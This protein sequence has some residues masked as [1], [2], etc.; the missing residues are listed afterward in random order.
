MPHATGHFWLRVF[1][2]ILNLK[3]IRQFTIFSSCLNIIKLLTLA[4]WFP[5]LRCCNEC[6]FAGVWRSGGRKSLKVPTHSARNS[7]KVWI[8]NRG[9]K[10]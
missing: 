6:R 3:K 5:I 4:D 9:L 2:V 7:G 1:W 8:E 10:K